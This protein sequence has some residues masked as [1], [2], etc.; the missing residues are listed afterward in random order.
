MLPNIL[1]NIGTT[2]QRFTFQAGGTGYL[3]DLFTSIWR[4]RTRG[5]GFQVN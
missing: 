5:S 3:Q 4:P 1:A 2:D